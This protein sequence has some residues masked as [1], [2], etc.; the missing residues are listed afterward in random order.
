MV[1]DYIIWKFVFTTLP[2][3]QKDNH[4]WEKF[5]NS[6]H[7]SIKGTKPYSLAI[8]IFYVFLINKLGK[9]RKIKFWQI[10]TE[11]VLE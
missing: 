9:G 11:V 3:S 5:P 2:K 10:L 1:D 8:F 7:W 4:Q 6:Q